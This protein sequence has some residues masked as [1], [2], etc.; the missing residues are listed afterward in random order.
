MRTLRIGACLLL[1][2]SAFFTAAAMDRA[3]SLPQYIHTLEQLRQSV[4][5]ATGS[6]SVLSS[7]Q[8]LPSEWQVEVDGQR[9]DVSTSD[10]GQGLQQYAK[11]RNA[12]N[13]AA[14]TAQIDLL[15]G[16][17]RGMQ[18]EKANAAAEREKLAEIL[19]RREF[20]DV[21]GESWF[22]RW[23]LAAQRW[24]AQ[25]LERVLLSSAFPVVSRVLIWGLLAVAIAAAAFWVVRNYRQ[26]NIYTQLTGSPD[27][28][29]GKLW[30]DWQSE[31]QAAAQ[32]GRWR[33]AVH[34]SYWAAISF[35]EAQGLWRPD[36]ARTPREYIRL[37]PEGNVCRDPLQQLTR[38]FEKV[39]Y[40]TENAT[41][42]TFAG[43][44]TL[45][46]RLGCR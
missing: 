28:P 24:F 14:I 11:Q 31:A 9:F 21:Q 40:G 36:N 10:V 46:E 12:Q 35:L 2:A 38:T 18:G 33:D 44:A 32:E 6:A 22:D 1:L 34:L 16:D 19:A 4:K 43:T 23:K 20:H 8:Q 5:S 45:L 13:L 27:A 42:D 15:L 39:W 25:L 29:S 26:S 7:L 41:A 30:R 37:L 3:L 17:A